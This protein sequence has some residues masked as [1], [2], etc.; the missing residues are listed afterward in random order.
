MKALSL[1]PE[2]AHQI[3][4]GEKNIE[5]RTWQTKHRGDLLICSSANP[6]RKGMISGHALIVCTLSDIIYNEHDGIYE[7]HLTNFRE[8]IPFPVKGKLNLY[9][10]DDSL[11]KYLPSDMT[12]EEAEN[13]YNKYFVPLM[14]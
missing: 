3:L 13:Y 1:K 14:A 4:C 10:V 5:Y 6:K 11:I 8:I 12:D 2:W 7:W 9:D